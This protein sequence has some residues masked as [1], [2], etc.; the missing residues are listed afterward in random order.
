MEEPVMSSMFKREGIWY[1]KT[2]TQISECSL[3]L[4]AGNSIG[5]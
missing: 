2:V 5:S 1:P 4:V 3:E